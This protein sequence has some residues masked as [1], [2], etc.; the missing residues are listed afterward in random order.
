MSIAKNL[1]RRTKYTLCHPKLTETPSLQSEKIYIYD[2]KTLLIFLH[3]DIVM[4]EIPAEKKPTPEAGAA[5]P[6]GDTI[7]IRV[8]DQV[9]DWRFL[10]FLSPPLTSFYNSLSQT[11]EE[12]F[13][14]VK[15][16]TRMEK[17]CCP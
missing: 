1:Y 11:G 2:V 4:A 16:T 8:R 17:V 3:V 7:T 13:F 12:T 9:I 6:D 15:K 5:A 14:K 10:L